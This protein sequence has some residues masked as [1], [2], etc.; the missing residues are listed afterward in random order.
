VLVYKVEGD[1]LLL[2][3]TETGTHGDLGW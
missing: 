3:L 2:T 1:R